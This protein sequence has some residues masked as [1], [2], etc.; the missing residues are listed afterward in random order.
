M[1]DRSLDEIIQDVLE[2]VATPDETARLRERLAADPSSVARRRELE[3]IFEALARMRMEESP[4]DLRERVMSALATE[5][6]EHRAPVNGPIA[7]P[8]AGRAPAVRSHPSPGWLTTWRAALARRPA[9]TLAYGLL[10]G[11]ALGALATYLLPTADELRSRTALVSGAMAPAERA[12][13]HRELETP[14]GRLRLETWSVPAGLALRIAP[15]TAGHFRLRL[16]LPS[17]VRAMAVR[18]TKNA[19]APGLSP[20]PEGLDLAL[21]GTGSWVVELA[22]APTATGSMR[23]HW[24]GAAGRRSAELELPPNGP[25]AEAAPR[26]R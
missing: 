3:E 13:T 19:G 12:R 8:G 6:L 20:L 21:E 24:D 2:G 9:W 5:P 15:S 22:R 7:A 4:V 1:N 17:G 25:P 10:A 11:V 14:E 23:V 18:W 26:G 16:E